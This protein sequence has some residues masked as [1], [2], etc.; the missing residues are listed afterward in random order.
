MPSSCP[1]LLLYRD[2]NLSVTAL[3]G[4]KMLMSMSSVSFDPQKNPR[5]TRE[6]S[7]STF[8]GRQV[9]RLVTGAAFICHLLGIRLPRLGGLHGWSV[10]EW[11]FMFPL[12]SSLT[13]TTSPFVSLS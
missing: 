10:V 1:L 8:T 7:F 3:S 11:D 12:G 5:R 4:L 6:G 2:D 13:D 9:W